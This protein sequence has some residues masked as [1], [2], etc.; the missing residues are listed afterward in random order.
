MA[1]H[2]CDKGD[3]R[4]I[5]CNRGSDIG[6][7]CNECFEEL[8]REFTFGYSS[9]HESHTFWDNV[10]PEIDKDYEFNDKFGD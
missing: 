3:C 4:N 9:Y 10:F 8:V 1:Y 6:Y 2:E 7:I 5:I